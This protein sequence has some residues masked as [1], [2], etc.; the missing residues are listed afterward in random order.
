MATPGV[1]LRWFALI[2]SRKAM[3]MR[4]AAVSRVL[5][6]TM[7][8]K[9]VMFWFYLM[10]VYSLCTVLRLSVYWLIDS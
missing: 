6:L 4:I 9:S 7:W 2:A 10:V 5:L 1:G 3:A 8:V